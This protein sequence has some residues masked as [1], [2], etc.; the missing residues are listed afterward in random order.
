MMNNEESD[1]EHLVSSSETFSSYPELRAHLDSHQQVHAILR[2]STPLFTS[3]HTN[4]DAAHQAYQ[5]FRKSILD[6]PVT[7]LPVVVTAI[8]VCIEKCKA[9]P[10]VAA[11]RLRLLQD[12]C[13]ESGIFP[14]MYWIRGVHL[15]R[16]IAWGSDTII[17]KGDYQKQT[18]AVR[19]CQHS[20]KQSEDEQH[21]QLKLF[22]R[23]II[24]H[25]QLHHPNL[26]DIIGISKSTDTFSSDEFLD[27]V[28]VLVPLPNMVLRYA[29]HGSAADYLR[30]DLGSWYFLHVVKG[31]A[32]G[33]EY[34]H[35]RF[36]PIV[37]GDL[38]D[39]NVVVTGSGD[40]L[41]CDFGRSRIHHITPRTNT[42]FSGDARLRFA[43]PELTSGDQVLG[44]EA[45]DIYSLAMT[46]YSLG[47][48]KPPLDNV[49]GNQ[50]AVR[51]MEK[52]ERPRRENDA[53]TFRRLDNA[54]SSKVWL[55]LEQMWVH[56]SQDRPSASTVC[57]ILAKIDP[58]S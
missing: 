33:L 28:G 2:S 51:Q 48:G 41:I 46:I 57:G 31:V 36:P 40:A 22:R 24:T 1:L 55:L 17:Y 18:V 3:T 42:Q 32:D 4:E 19:V 13:Q 54:T 35:S 5:S 53:E 25:W 20:H 58:E 52:G 15:Q 8:Q 45:S 37:H 44:N 49:L 26:V 16:R 21:Q 50:R 12:V 39:H 14:E 47:V 34:L 30:S 7:E 23:E 38:H 6:L 56:E 11:L 27:A 29:E 43:A 9:L 10:L